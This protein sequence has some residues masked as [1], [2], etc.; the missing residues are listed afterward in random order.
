MRIR[1]TLDIDR[2]RPDPEPDEPDEPHRQGDV[3]TNAQP[4]GYQPI[5]F[6]INTSLD[7]D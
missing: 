7:N 5:G 4:V 3:Y 6:Q 2:R 1:F